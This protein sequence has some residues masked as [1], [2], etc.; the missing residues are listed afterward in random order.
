MV[1]FFYRNV[2]FRKG[3]LGR[4]GFL[5]EVV[6]QEWSTKSCGWEQQICRYQEYHI[7]I[8]FGYIDRQDTRNCTA[9]FVLNVKPLKLCLPDIESGKVFLH[10]C[11]IIRHTPQILNRDK[12]SYGSFSKK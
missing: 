9:D 2:K 5:N 8:S 4:R 7:T 3:N 10:G 6:K 11:I 12:F 1:F